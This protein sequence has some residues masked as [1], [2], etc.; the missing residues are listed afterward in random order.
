M[1]KSQIH[2]K[3]TPMHFASSL[4][5]GLYLVEMSSSWN[6][7]ALA[8]PSCE[9]SEPSRGTLIF[10]LKQSWQ[11]RQYV[12]QYEANLSSNSKTAIKF[13]NFYEYM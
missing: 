11:F 12:C 13:P 2:F 3:D 8:S 4:R 10:E 7:P 1:S 6:F 9:G 5:I